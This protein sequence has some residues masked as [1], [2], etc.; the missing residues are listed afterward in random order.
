MSVNNLYIWQEFTKIPIIKKTIY[1]HANKKVSLEFRKSIILKTIAEKKEERQDLANTLTKLIA[2]THGYDTKDKQSSI[3]DLNDMF[4]NICNV[5]RTRFTMTQITSKKE[6]ALKA[7]LI[8]ER[9]SK[10]KADSPSQ[11]HQK[12][13]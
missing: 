6:K 1:I 4:Q 5:I 11:L 2:A 7:K 9:Q 8:E 12:N 10:M 3:Q 13:Y